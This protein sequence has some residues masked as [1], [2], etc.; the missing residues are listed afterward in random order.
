MF[1][2]LDD[3]LRHY[4]ELMLELNNP[5]VAEDQRKFRKLMKEQA[6]LAPI[7]DAYKQ[8]KQAKQDVEDS[9]ALLDEESDEE[10]KE[11][12]KEELADAKKRI[13]EL[14]QELKILLLP[15]DPNDEKN[16]I[17]EI[18]AGAGGDEAALF[19]S[20]LY[21]MYVHY[22]ESQHW[23]TEMINVSESGIGGMKEVEFMITGHGAYSKLKYESGVHRVQ[24]VPETES[25]GRIHTSTATVA[26]MPEAEEFDVVIDDKDIRIDV[27]RASGNGGQC[28]NTTD[29]AVRLTHIPTGIVIYSQ[30]EKSQLQNKEKAFRLLRSKL[31][32]M[33]LERRQ[34]EEAAERRSQI[35]TGDRSEKI[36]T[37]NF[38]QGRVT[39]HRIK[40]TLYKIDA[41]MDG[42]IQELI[43]SLIAA[44]QAAKLAKMNEN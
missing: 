28:V 41:I 35:G 2:R 42:D 37:Y 8:Y 36:R 39:D 5:S 15:K 16:V 18:R 6:D 34:N 40:L 23:K 7:V 27:M 38:P 10:M 3:M 19:A 26:I 17:V 11:L 44:D 22:A 24:R 13:E 20:E 43:D 1:D 12:A 25:G 21:R 14:E 29:S 32:D 9:L 31:Y 33:E 30:T 4:E